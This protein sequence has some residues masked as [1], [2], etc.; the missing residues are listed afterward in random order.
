[1]EAAIAIGSGVLRHRALVDDHP[2]PAELVS[3]HAEAEGEKGFLHR[4][5]DFTAIGEQ[6]MDT[7]RFVRAAVRQ[8]ASSI[9]PPRRQN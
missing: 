8:A 1:M 2:R 6:R 9:K 7:L 5:E 4:H 3:E